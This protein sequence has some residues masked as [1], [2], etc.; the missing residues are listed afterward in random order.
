MSAK[1]RLGAVVLDDGG[2][3][4]R[5]EDHGLYEE[6]EYGRYCHLGD[7]LGVKTFLRRGLLTAQAEFLIGRYLQAHP[8]TTGITSEVL[9]CGMA[10]VEVGGEWKSRPV[11]WMK[12]IE[13]VNLYRHAIDLGWE[14]HPE[15]EKVQALMWGLACPEMQPH[16]YRAA[17]IHA[18]LQQT[19]YSAWDHEQTHN[20]ML[21]RERI[22]AIDFRPQKD[23][24]GNVVEQ[25]AFM[26]QVYHEHADDLDL[27]LP[28]CYMATLA[29][30]G[31]L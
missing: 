9:A 14:S 13:G 4:V 2:F 1:C 12:H 27:T 21:A 8:L 30:L 25:R 11:I 23:I 3:M 15:L 20:Y 22:I 16:L 18:L 24:N 5:I 28:E 19:G 26:R 31:C 29:K 7:G 10:S 6:G 17:E